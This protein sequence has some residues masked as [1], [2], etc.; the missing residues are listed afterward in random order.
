MKDQ[1]CTLLITFSDGK[2][3]IKQVTTTHTFT[4]TNP[5]HYPQQ[6]TV[7]YSEG[8]DEEDINGEVRPVTTI[9][10]SSA[11]PFGKL[12]EDM[13][14]QTPVYRIRSQPF[15]QI[16]APVK[17]HPTNIRELNVLY[18]NKKETRQTSILPISGGLPR[19]DHRIVERSHYHQTPQPQQQTIVTPPIS[20]TTSKPI[21][22]ETPQ[23]ATVRVSTSDEAKST[24]CKKTNLP[25]P[26]KRNTTGLKK[27]EKKP[28]TSDKMPYQHQALS[29]ESVQ[30]SYARGNRETRLVYERHVSETHTTRKGHEGSR[31]GR[32]STGYRT[33]QP[34]AR[35]SP[36]PSTTI[37]VQRS[38]AIDS[39]GYTQANLRRLPRYHDDDIRLYT[40]Y[41]DPPPNIRPAVNVQRPIV[42]DAKPKSTYII[43]EWR[44]EEHYAI[45]HPSRG[46]NQT[47]K[48]SQQAQSLSTQTAEPLKVDVGLSTTQKTSSPVSNVRSEQ[49]QDQAMRIIDYSTYHEEMER[50]QRESV[51]RRSPS[52]KGFDS[53]SS[54]P[55]TPTIVLP[56]KPISETTTNVKSS[57]VFE[58]SR[59]QQHSPQKVEPTTTQS[60]QVDSS[61][62]NY[63]YVLRT[64]ESREHHESSLLGE[65]QTR[66]YPDTSPTPLNTPM[67]P[68]S[69][70]LFVPESD[71]DRHIREV[72]MESFK[73]KIEIL[74]S[75]RR[76]RQYDGMTGGSPSPHL[77]S[78]ATETTTRRADSHASQH[79]E[80]FSAA[81]PAQQTITSF[82]ATP[83]PVDEQQTAQKSFEPLPSTPSP[84]LHGVLTKETTHQFI[85]DRIV[86]RTPQST[87]IGRTPSPLQTT[88]Q[89]EQTLSK[90]EEM[91]EPEETVFSIY[92][93]KDRLSSP[94]A[95]VVPDESPVIDVEDE[96]ERRYL[97]SVRR[98]LSYEE[99]ID[100][101]IR[102]R[103]R[104][105]QLRRREE[106]LATAEL[107]SIVDEEDEHLVN[108]EESTIP[109]A[110]PPDEQ[111]ETTETRVYIDEI[112]AR[113]EGPLELLSPKADVRFVEFSP[114][115][116]PLI[117]LP[118]SADTEVQEVTLVPEKKV[119]EEE[120]EFRFDELIE[121]ETRRQM[122]QIRERTPTKYESTTKFESKVTSE[123]PTFPTI[124]LPKTL[125][126]S[127]DELKY[128]YAEPLPSM[129]TR[130]EYRSNISSRANFSRPQRALSPLGSQGFTTN[131]RV[132]KILTESSSVGGSGFSPYG[133]SSAATTI[134]DTRE[135]E[136]KEMSDLNDR[137]ASYIEKVRF[138]E[139]QN[140]KLATD[141]E[142]LRSRY[143][144]DS[145][146]VRDMYEGDLKQ[147]RRVYEEAEKL[148]NDLLEECRLLQED[149]NSYRRKYDDALRS[150]ELN[151][152]QLEDLLN[153][154][155]AL[156]SELNLLRR[157]I[158]NLEADLGS[159]KRENHHLI[160]ALQ[161]ARTDLDQETLN[162][163]DYQNQAQ[164]LIEEI[165]FLRRAHD[166]EIR[167]LQAMASRDTT[168][169]NRE[170]FKNELAAAIRDIRGEYDQLTTVHRTDMESWYKLKVQ[171]IQTQS[172]RHNM[173]QTYA[174]DEI[175]RLRSQ[176]SDL[177]GKLADLEGRNAILEKNLEELNFQLEDDQRNY[178]SALNDRDTQ[179]RKIRDECQMLMVE[180]QMLLDTKQTLDAEIAIYR[181]ML[182]GEEDRAGL[183]QLVE[184]VVRTHHVRQADE[185]ESM[186]V[187]R[188]ETSS[189]HSYQRSAKGNVS[190][191]EAAP[192]GR[193]VILENTHR[194]REEYIGEWKLKR[195]I[196]N[197]RDIVYT[198]P[199]DFVLAPG[200]SV[201]I[202]ARN[203]GVLSPPDQLIFNEEDSFGVGSHVQ[204]ILYNTQGEERATL[205][206]RSSQN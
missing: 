89:T 104:D 143:G 55:L 112:S 92:P 107:L 133:G 137:L 194:A 13:L 128:R 125:T 158:S 196:D 48:Q 204:T 186:R 155:S 83:L 183:R 19:T 144:K 37:D 200:K 160:T 25:T 198:F 102:R 63:K 161:R 140:R 181:K 40:R 30:E 190:I 99:Q 118:Q 152:E 172:A 142:F 52:K 159:T 16:H 117:R 203:Q 120:D 130:T 134:R 141:L 176:L 166:S 154:L 110:S 66:G 9:L 8:K 124:K 22:I 126:T 192:D 109:I 184:T 60:K 74:K 79:S 119:D 95:T 14:E 82:P 87:E 61:S 38:T 156:E 7:A 206:Q 108:V 162:R 77:I 50:L 75:S 135:R 64:R 174:A 15:A 62:P 94:E 23:K 91:A 193:Y 97:E 177:R 73:E 100:L 157:R 34:I 201:K 153:R 115:Q 178:E 199:R 54:V 114:K 4:S 131:S 70:P 121:T 191:S 111:I 21:R 20:V 46:S 170:Y 171:E 116:P 122:E 169:E 150:R 67:S 105:E 35:S 80:T 56:T 149:I 106:D 202:S 71:A 36:P 113:Y 84:R 27:E 1:L 51:D 72:S 136:K 53:F 85:T 103:R 49:S 44:E 101:E 96:E 78:P 145:V 69:S 165:E 197:R 47:A 17:S 179:I 2:D 45:R 43:E 139:A 132:L 146:N 175:K 5:D 205:I 57:E 138:L 147:A 123:R 180:L 29:Y 11:V 98:N 33:S 58:T 18:E 76:F 65:T 188:G 88:T 86:T 93:Q 68:T 12:G 173:E 3:P 24:D 81:S 129:D 90:T 185:S 189:R 28:K 148:R 182:E 195:I 31:N 187:L 163:I 6:R 168:S 164:T 167:D 32:Q 39:P 127:T 151:K 26:P 59:D 10:R 41:G 42:S